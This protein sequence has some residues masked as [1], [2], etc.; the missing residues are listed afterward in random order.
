MRTNVLAV[1][2]IPML[3]AGSTGTSQALEWTQS[4]FP[5]EANRTVQG[6]ADRFTDDTYVCIFV[7]CDDDGKLSL[8]FTAPGPD[9]VGD[10]KLMVDGASFAVSVPRS[11]KSQLPISS[12]AETI[13][14]GLLEAM[15]SGRV[16]LIQGAK[17]KRGYDRISLRKARMAIDRVQQKCGH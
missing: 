7:R 12:R 4:S 3:S 10:I 15:K 9:I 5:G 16:M 11:L 13:P 8:H 17:L 2:L 14:P 1:C 6:C